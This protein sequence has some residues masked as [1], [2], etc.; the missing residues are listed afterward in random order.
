MRDS[1]RRSNFNNFTF[2]PLKTRFHI[3]LGAHSGVL[4]LFDRVLIFSTYFRQMT[5]ISL[6]FGYGILNR[7]YRV[8]KFLKEVDICWIILFLGNIKE[9]FWNQLEIVCRSSF[10]DLLH[11]SCTFFWLSH[12][13]H[14]FI[15]GQS[16]RFKIKIIV[17]YC[18]ETPLLGRS[19]LST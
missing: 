11:Q 15:L 19:W 2:H 16:W 6:L 4:P 7:T 10:F 13:M 8:P 9:N 18:W 1:N 12:L 17:T 3:H 5:T 14:L